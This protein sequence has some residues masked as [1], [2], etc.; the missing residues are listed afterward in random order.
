L[1]DEIELNSFLAQSIFAF[2]IADKSIEDIEPLVSAIKKICFTSFL[3][4]AIA[5]SGA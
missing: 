4:I 3:L 5:Q 2:S 1:S